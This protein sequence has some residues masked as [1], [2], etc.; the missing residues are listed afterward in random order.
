MKCKTKNASDLRCA[1][2]NCVTQLF[3]VT[4]H[5]RAR[6]QDA[7]RSPFYVLDP[8]IN[9][10]VPLTSSSLYF[11]G[12]R[13]SRPPL[14]KYIMSTHHSTRVHSACRGAI[15]DSRILALFGAAATVFR[16]SCLSSGIRLQDL[17]LGRG[18]RAWGLA[19]PGPGRF[20]LRI[21]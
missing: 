15:R 17:N 9:L 2:A 12:S 8:L 18:A 19:P 1:L 5:C 4:G 13:K 11:Y 21:Y 7:R 10:M 20:P 16:S 6:S 14:R 3:S